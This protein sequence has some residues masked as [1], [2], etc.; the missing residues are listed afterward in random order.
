MF[1]PIGFFAAVDSAPPII[2]DSLEQWMDVTTAGG[3]E[4]TALTDKSGNGRNLTNNGLTWDATNNWFYLSSNTDWQNHIDTG[5]RLSNFGDSNS[6]SI[7]MWVRAQDIAAAD[8]GLY[9]NRTSTY[10]N[11]YLVMAMRDELDFGCALADDAGNEAGSLNGPTVYDDAWVLMNLGVDGSTN[12]GYIRGNGSQEASFSTSAIETINRN[13]NIHL[14][15][16]YL[17]SA[18]YF[19][20]AQFGSY[21]I[22]S[23]FLSNDE[24]LQN[25]NAEKAHFGL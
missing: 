16:P 11:N 15:G 3:S 5:Y 10:S 12:T 4:S 17:N 14:V 9:G 22:Y 8:A 21:R 25:Y 19:I 13:E 6:W 2:T 1:T 20:D 23:K 24:C 7:E 18:K